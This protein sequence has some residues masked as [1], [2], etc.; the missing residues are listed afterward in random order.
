[1]YFEVDYQLSVDI[2]QQVS[3]QPKHCWHNSILGQQVL[4][5]ALYIEG[6]IVVPEGVVIEHGWLE[7]ESKIVDPTLV[8][9]IHEESEVPRYFSGIYYTVEE[10]FEGLEATDGEL[11]LVYR[12]G[13]WGRVTAPYMLAYCDAWEYS[14]AH[15]D[16]DAT[17]EFRQHIQGVRDFHEKRIESAANAL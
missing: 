6:W 2:A 13:C 10:S 7:M 12:D 14:F 5:N 17:D 3:A 4:P 11:P 15:C 16:V 9:R 1:M 8:P